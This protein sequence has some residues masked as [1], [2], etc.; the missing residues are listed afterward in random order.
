MFFFSIYNGQFDGFK[1][2]CGFYMLSFSRI[3]E[4]I[5]FILKQ[6]IQGE[7]YILGYIF[8]FDEIVS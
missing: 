4:D 8:S 6:Q 3:W 1:I 7:G 5:F 2:Y